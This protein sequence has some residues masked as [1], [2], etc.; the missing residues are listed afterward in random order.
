MAENVIL[1]K[2]ELEKLQIATD[3]LNKLKLSLGELEI[4]KLDLFGKVNALT[5]EFSKM[6]QSLI[7]KY[8]KDSVINIKTGEV[9]KK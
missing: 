7:E 1:E 8:G 2:E 9:K 4:Q 5:Q 6:E 3:S